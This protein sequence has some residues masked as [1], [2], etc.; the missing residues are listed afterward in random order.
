VFFAYAYLFDVVGGAGYAPDGT[1]DRLAT[2]GKL[3]D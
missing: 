3:R 2:Y 1:P